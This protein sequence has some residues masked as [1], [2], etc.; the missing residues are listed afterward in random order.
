MPSKEQTITERIEACAQAMAAAKRRIEEAVD[1]LEECE[2][3]LPRDAQILTYYK[4]LLR[5][6][7]HETK[8]L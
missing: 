4:T 3:H 2:Q 6:I 1:Q 7:R 5:M 8:Y